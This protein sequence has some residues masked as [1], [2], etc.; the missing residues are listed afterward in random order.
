MIT[1][2]DNHNEYNASFNQL[3]SLIIDYLAADYI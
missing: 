2:L 1:I 3:F